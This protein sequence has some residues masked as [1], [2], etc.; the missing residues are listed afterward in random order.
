MTGCFLNKLLRVKLILKDLSWC[1]K[2]SMDVESM[3]FIKNFF[4]LFR[5]AEVMLVEMASLV[6]MVDL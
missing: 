6:K 5:V 1:N 2:Q 4:L 3:C